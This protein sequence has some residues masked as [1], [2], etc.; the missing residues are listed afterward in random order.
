MQAFLLNKQFLEKHAYN[1]GMQPGPKPVKDQPFFGERMAYYRKQ[2][3]LTQQELAKE[4]EISRELVGHYERRCENPSIEFL[5]KLSKVIDIS[6]DELLGLKPEKP[7]KGPS[8]K[9]LKLAER[10]SA[11][12]RNKQSFVIGMIEGAIKQAS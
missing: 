4:L 3:G 7:K 8:P 9:A 1:A 11:L 6:I 10:I 5:I 12:P 2:K